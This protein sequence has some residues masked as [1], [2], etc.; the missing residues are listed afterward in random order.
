MHLRSVI[1]PWLGV[2]I[3]L[4]LIVGAGCSSSNRE[5]EAAPVQQNVDI[6]PEFLTEPAVIL[7]EEDRIEVN[8]DEA[9]HTYILHKK[10]LKS[11]HSEESTFKFSTDKNREIVS[12]KARAVYPD[13]RDRVLTDKDI[14]DIPDFSGFVLY[15]DKRS[16]AFDFPGIRAGTVI[17]VEVRSRIKNLAY[18]PPGL[19]QSHVPMVVRRYVLVHPPDAEYTV[20][21]LN[22]S[23]EPARRSVHDDGS[24]E[25]IWEAK[26]IAAFE[27]EE[28]MPP[29]I[30]FMPSLWFST[31]EEV[32]LG[33]DLRLDSWNDIVEWYR[34]LTDERLAPSREVEE[35]VEVLCPGSLSEGAKARR[36]FNW[37]QENL[38]YVAIYLG[39]GGYLPHGADDIIRNRYG[40]CKISPSCWCRLSEK[41]GLRLTSCSLERRISA[42]LKTC[43]LLQGTSTTP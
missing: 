7:L 37:V 12:I 33:V 21:S 10:I 8:G 15:S 4:S 38:R 30:E 26:N 27:T 19:F 5:F 35:L 22:M 20:R 14:V 13:G 39:L 17:A 42:I 34:K 43:L 24:H 28:M 32:E 11:S 41:L 9:F 31:H 2:V 25:I 18:W 6:P 29:P 40:D 23:K 3:A 1:S 16:R 36:I